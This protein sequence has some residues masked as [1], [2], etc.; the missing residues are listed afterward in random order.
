MRL[1]EILTRRCEALGVDL[2]F[3]TDVTDD[4]AQA[5]EFGATS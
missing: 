3:A 4:E 2:R 5:R 1:L